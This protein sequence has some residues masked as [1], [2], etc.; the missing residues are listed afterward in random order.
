M[1][2]VINGAGW[3]E[4]S[5][6]QPNTGNVLFGEYENSGSGSN[7]KRASFATAL[8]SPVAIADVLND[9]YQS[10]VDAGYLS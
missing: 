1:S 8:S 7:G 9:G 10:W 3:S 4:W 6:S 5:K 2:D